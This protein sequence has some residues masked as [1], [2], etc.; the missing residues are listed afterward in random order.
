MSRYG[1]NFSPQKRMCCGEWFAGSFGR[2][3]G[4]LTL[5]IF[6]TLLANTWTELQKILRSCSPHRHITFQ[7]SEKFIPLIVQ[8]DIVDIDRAGCG[9]AGGDK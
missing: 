9:A 6:C 4:G 8:A 3:S 7:P 2:S 5:E 1:E